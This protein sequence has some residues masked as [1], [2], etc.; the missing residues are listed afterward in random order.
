MFRRWPVS[1]PDAELVRRIGELPPSPLDRG[2]RL[3]GHAADH[4]RLWFAIAAPLASR[5]GAQRRAGLRGVAAIGFASFGASLVG[6]RLFPR[7]RPAAELL[8]VERRMSRRPTSS[9]FPSGHAA[10]ATAFASAV[11]MECPV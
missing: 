2:F 11:A 1:R 5:K 9:S 8:P 10:S 3:L 6:K 4:S 7:R